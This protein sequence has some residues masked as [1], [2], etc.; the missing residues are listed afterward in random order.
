MDKTIIAHLKQKLEEEKARLEKELGN[1]TGGKD[2][3]DATAD[4]EFPEF[5]SKEDENAAEVANFSDNLSLEEKIEESI[6]DVE[7]ALASITAGTYGTCKYCKN[8]IDLRRL[9]ARPA[10]S[11]CIHCKEAIKSS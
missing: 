6:G 2:A 3:S 8:D 1:V 10:S 11:S 4:A 9:E 5:G 7:K